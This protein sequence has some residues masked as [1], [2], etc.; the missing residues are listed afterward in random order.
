MACDGH[1]ELQEGDC[2]RQERSINYRF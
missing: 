2:R 1:A